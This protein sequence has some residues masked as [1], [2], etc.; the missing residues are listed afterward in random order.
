MSNL[1]QY[2]REKV[3]QVAQNWRHTNVIEEDNQLME[4]L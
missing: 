1:L 2:D 4:R 3:N